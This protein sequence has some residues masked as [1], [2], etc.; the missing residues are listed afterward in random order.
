[1]DKLAS[2]AVVRKCH[3]GQEICG[4]GQPAEYWYRVTSGTARRCVTRPD[5]RRQIVELLL[6]GDFFGFTTRREYDSTVEAVAEDTIVASYPRRRVK[7]LAEADPQLSRENLPGDVRGSLTFANPTDDP[8]SDYRDRGGRSF[9]LTMAELLSDQTLDRVDLPI[10]RYDI[11]DY[12][13]L[14]VETVCR[15]LTSLKKRGLMA[16]SGPRSVRII[17]RDALEEGGA[18]DVYPKHLGARRGC[19]NLSAHSS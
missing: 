13:G 19:A 6:P 3:R 17:D 10:S 11:A 16:L 2:I 12:L 8:R 1:M 9:L 18:C 14:S 5:G 4:Q 7:M 15:S